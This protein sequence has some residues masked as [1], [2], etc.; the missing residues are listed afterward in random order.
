MTAGSRVRECDFMMLAMLGSW[1]GVECLVFIL[2]ASS[3]QGLFAAG[4]FFALPKTAPPAAE[5]DEEDEDSFRYFCDSLR[6]LP[7]L[8]RAGMALLPTVDSGSHLRFVWPGG[9]VKLGS[10][11]RLKGLLVLLAGLALSLLSWWSFLQKS[12]RLAKRKKNFKRS[13]NSLGW[14]RPRSMRRRSRLEGGP[15]ERLGALGPFQKK[16]V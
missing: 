3:V 13:A 10:S 7:A 4:V 12:T 14:S 9:T 1:L 5:L 16:R 15:A 2:L 6:P 8:C 11:L